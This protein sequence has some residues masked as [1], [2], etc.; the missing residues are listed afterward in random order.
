[1]PSS[2]SWVWRN[3]SSAG[4]HPTRYHRRFTKPPVFPRR[5][6]SQPR[7]RRGLPSRRCARDDALFRGA[8]SPS[9]AWHP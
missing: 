8:T 4:R 9:A 5:Y 2:G 1:M 6:I 3:R 7:R